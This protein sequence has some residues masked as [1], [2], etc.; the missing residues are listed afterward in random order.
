MLAVSRFNPVHAIM[1][2]AAP[3]TVSKINP[4]FTSPHVIRIWLGVWLVSGRPAQLRC[5][6]AGLLPSA[7]S[8]HTWLTCSESNPAW[9]VSTNLLKSTGYRD[10]DNLMIQTDLVLHFHFCFAVYQDKLP[11]KI[12]MVVSAAMLSGLETAALS[13]RQRA[14]EKMLSF[15]VTRMD[16][17]RRERGTVNV[18]V[19]CPSICTCPPIHIRIH[20]HP[21]RTTEEPAKHRKC[22][23]VCVERLK[24]AEVRTGRQQGEQRGDLWL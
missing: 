13:K 12:V 18:Y 5:D 14:D 15:S 21:P 17:I 1:R 2:V 6:S 10:R 3:P 9:I 23:S 24:E 19:H 8:G 20:I 22:F 11:F 16:R 7:N 4:Q